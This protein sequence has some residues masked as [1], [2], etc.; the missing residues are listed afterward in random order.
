MHVRDTV[1]EDAEEP[2]ALVE[3]VACE[4]RFLAATVGFPLDGAGGFTASVKAARG[5]H[6]G[7]HRV[8]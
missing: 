8:A 3:S 2:A 1:E 5:V 7:G 4:R 6:I